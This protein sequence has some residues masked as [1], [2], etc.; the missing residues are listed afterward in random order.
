MA[1]LLRGWMIASLLVCGGAVHGQDE[2]VSKPIAGYVWGGMIFATIDKKDAH[3]KAKGKPK[4]EIDKLLFKA[5][6]KYKSFQ[7]LREEIQPVYEA[8]ESWVFPKNRLM[9]RL[10]SRGKSGAGAI[11]IDIQLW[12]NKKVLVKTDA[13]VGKSSPVIIEGPPWGKG[14]LLFVLRLADPPEKEKQ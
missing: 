7:V 11:R 1:R 9:L 10:D 8:Y 2:I 12:Q 4:P 6:P 3:S 5:F 14:R 13:I